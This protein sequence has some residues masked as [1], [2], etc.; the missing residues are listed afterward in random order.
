MYPAAGEL[1]Q[2]FLEDYLA[3]L[4][5]K[6]NPTNPFKGMPQEQLNERKEFDYRPGDLQKYHERL[7]RPGPSLPLVYENN[8]YGIDYNTPRTE[9]E[10]MEE[11][12]YRDLNN[13][14]PR[15]IRLDPTQLD[16]QEYRRP[17]PADM[18]EDIDR[19]RFLFSPRGPI[20]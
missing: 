18:Y 9:S 10:Y 15:G 14:R 8:R 5:F 3:G 20:A 17:G 12:F 11:E 16:L 4:S 19:D 13:P 2:N 6:I 7:N 1:A